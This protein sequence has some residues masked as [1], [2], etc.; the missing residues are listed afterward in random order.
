MAAKTYY[1]RRS[2]RNALKT[3]LE[4]KGWINLN[5]GE[6]FQSEETIKVPMVSVYFLPNSGK[7]FQLGKTVENIYRRRVQIDCYMESESRAMAITDDIMDFM[8]ITPIDIQNESSV[9]LGS[10]ICYDTDSISSE[11]MPPNLLNPKVNRWRGISS[12]TFEAF[13]SS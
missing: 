8:D 9:S 2:F 4:T 1:E 6:G 13:Y 5:Y 11:T 10:L 7:A 12:G 3:F